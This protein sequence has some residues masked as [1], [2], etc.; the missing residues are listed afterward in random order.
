MHPAPGPEEVNWSAL[1]SDY[2]SRDLRRNLT[3]PLTLWTVLFPIGIFA[4]G[5]VQLDY[6]LCPEHK[7]G[8]LVFDASNA[9]LPLKRRVIRTLAGVTSRN[10]HAAVR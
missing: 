6:L 10:G 3:R 8:E 7:C 4:G 1:W 2:R 5:L 9:C